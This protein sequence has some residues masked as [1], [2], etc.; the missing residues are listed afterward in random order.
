MMIVSLCSVAAQSATSDAKPIV[1]NCEIHEGAA[2]GYR[3]VQ[4]MVDEENGIVIYNYERIGPEYKRKTEKGYI[5]LSMKI[6][7]SDDKQISANDNSGAFIMTKQDAKFAKAWVIG[8][9]LNGSVFP[10][11]NVHL[12][13]CVKNPFQ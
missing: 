10:W 11:G 5:D 1:L 12:G 13:S 6:S 8:V 9:P 4:I 7:F 3:S 2:E